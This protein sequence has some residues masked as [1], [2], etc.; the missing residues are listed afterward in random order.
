MG[1]DIVTLK[2]IMAEFQTSEMENTL[3]LLI[4]Q[5]NTVCKRMPTSLSVLQQCLTLTQYLV[6]KYPFQVLKNQQHF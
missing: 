2:S 3:Y 4:Y 1:N 6:S 5:G